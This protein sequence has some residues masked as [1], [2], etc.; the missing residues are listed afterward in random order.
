MAMECVSSRAFSFERS[1]STNG[2]NLRGL[3][4]TG[5]I[6]WARCAPN[7]VGGKHISQS[8]ICLRSSVFASSELKSPSLVRA[9]ELSGRK[10]LRINAAVGADNVVTEPA[11]S[12]NFATSLTVPGSSTELSFLGAGVREKQIAFL[13]VKVYAVG[14]YAEGQVRAS[15]KSWTGKSAAELATDDAVYKELAEAPVEKALQIVLARDVDGATFW[16]ALDEALVPRLKAGGAGADGDKALAAL[17]DVF[18]SRS[19]KKGFVITFTWVQPTSLK[20]ALSESPS[21]PLNNEASIE[22]KALLSALFDVFLGPNAVSPSA[23]L[24]VAD[25]IAKLI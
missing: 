20:I 25:G 3:I 5:R 15:L 9:S 14:V 23:K 13:K 18:R 11:T 17:G 6:F 22:S 8:L 7:V 21:A 4:S 19:L 1:S 2:P 16:G 12:I 10:R 24:A